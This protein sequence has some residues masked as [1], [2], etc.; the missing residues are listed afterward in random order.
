[1]LKIKRDTPAISLKNLGLVIR[2]QMPIHKLV[3]NLIVTGVAWGVFSKN[4][5]IALGTGKPKI[6]YPDKESASKAA[7]W[8]ERRYGGK[9]DGYKCI[10]CDD[11]HVGR[12]RTR[13]EAFRR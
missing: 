3:Y 6:R 10:Y 9:F 7:K 11:Y 12:N 2:D 13:L 1:M 4:S 8:M 5:H